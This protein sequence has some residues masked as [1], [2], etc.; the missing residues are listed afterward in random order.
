M[1]VINI[2][3]NIIAN[4]TYVEAISGDAALVSKATAMQEAMMHSFPMLGNFGAI[5]VAVCLLFFAFSTILSWNFFGKINVQ[6]LTKNSKI[7]TTLYS[8]IAIAFI[9]F[10]ALLSN[11]LVWELTDFFNYLMVL[12]NVIALIA[13][14]KIVAKNAKNK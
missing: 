3:K 7:A 8:I 10:G 5:F 9:F 2:Y 6:Y 14:W 13:L 1:M 4:G 12:P 11:D